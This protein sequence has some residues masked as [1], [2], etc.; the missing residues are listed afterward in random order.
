MDLELELEAQNPLEGAILA[1][2]KVGNSIN[3]A[4]KLLN[5]QVGSTLDSKRTIEPPKSPR[6]C[7]LFSLATWV[8]SVPQ[9]LPAGQP[10]MPSSSLLSLRWIMLSSRWSLRTPSVSEALL[11]CRARPRRPT[12]PPGN[13]PTIRPIFS[14]LSASSSRLPGPP[15][16]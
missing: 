3:R 4:E 13:H 1:R 8:P 15:A 6:C 7:G 11:A 14:R 12:P 16:A 2:R 10:Q 9:A 5:S